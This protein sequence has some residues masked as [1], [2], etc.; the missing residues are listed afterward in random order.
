MFQGVLWRI[1]WVF[2]YHFV[3]ILLP[4]CDLVVRGM[5]YVIRRLDVTIFL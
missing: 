3:I 5:D 4:Y 2:R 1:V